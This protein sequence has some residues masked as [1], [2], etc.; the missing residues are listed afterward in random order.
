[1][2]S[3][4]GKQWC[5]AYQKNWSVVVNGVRRLPVDRVFDGD[6]ASRHGAA[7]WGVDGLN[8]SLRFDF[9]T[10]LVVVLFVVFYDHPATCDN[11]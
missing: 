8:D 9:S 5:A 2:L 1:M 6:V 4:W 11:P 7:D 10:P 3:P